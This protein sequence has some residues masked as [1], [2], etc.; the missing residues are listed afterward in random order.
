MPDGRARLSPFRPALRASLH[1]DS[2]ITQAS[3][4]SLPTFRV[5]GTPRCD[6]RLSSGHHRRLIRRTAMTISPIRH[7]ERQELQ[8]I[9]RLHHK[10]RQT[11][12]RQPIP[13]PGCNNNS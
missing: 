10:P 11:I 13:R 3:Q 6:N 7:I 8:L 5:T 4:S 2:R 12:R 1:D 9:D